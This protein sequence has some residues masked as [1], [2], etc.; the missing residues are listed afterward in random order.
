MLQTSATAFPGPSTGSWVGGKAAGTG[1]G[2]VL[3]DVGVAN[4][5]LA[6]SASVLPLPPP[7]HTHGYCTMR[8]SRELSE[9]LRQ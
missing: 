1:P 9:D 3:C 5:G 4:G 2:T 7:P 6:R 8:G